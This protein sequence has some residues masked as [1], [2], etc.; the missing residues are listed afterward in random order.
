MVCIKMAEFG[1]DMYD[2]DNQDNGEVET[3]ATD[4]KKHLFAKECEQ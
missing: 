3:L 2:D 1:E 4:K